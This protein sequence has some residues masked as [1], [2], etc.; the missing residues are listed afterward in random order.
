MTGLSQHSYT[1]LYTT[2]HHVFSS[3]GARQFVTN[4]EASCRS[5][6]ADYRSKILMGYLLSAFHPVAEIDK[7]RSQAFGREYFEKTDGWR[8]R[9]QI[10]G[11]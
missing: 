8:V 1:I 2:H 10:F 11:D 4:F 7:K 9:V 5:M 6:A 3:Q